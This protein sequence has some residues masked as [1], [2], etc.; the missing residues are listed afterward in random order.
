MANTDSNRPEIITRTAFGGKSAVALGGN[1]YSIKS[2]ALYKSA[3]AVALP[4][5]GLAVDVALWVSFYAL[6]FRLPWSLALVGWL[7]PYMAL[8]L[9]LLVLLP[10][11]T[12]LGQVATALPDHTKDAWA[13]LFLVL[14]GLLVATN[15]FW[16]RG[17]LK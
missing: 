13:R 8:V 11:L 9:V 3:N 16:A 17:V 2:E 6:A 15:G 14:C 1:R 4:A 7:P 5:R 10:T 12:A